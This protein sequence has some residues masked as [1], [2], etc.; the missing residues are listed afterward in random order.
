[1]KTLRQWYDGLS[2][3]AQRWLTKYCNHWFDASED[4]CYRKIKK[5][6]IEDAVNDM[7][8]SMKSHCSYFSSDDRDFVIRSMLKIISASGASNANTLL[9]KIRVVY[10]DYLPS[11]YHIFY[12]K[13]K[14]DEIF[15][16]LH[17]K[18]T[19]S[20][21]EDDD[22]RYYLCDYL[23]TIKD[24]DNIVIDWN[25]IR[26][27]S[28]DTEAC[29]E[30]IIGR[31][32]FKHIVNDNLYAFIDNLRPR[33]VN[34]LFDELFFCENG[35]TKEQKSQMLR[36]KYLK[37]DSLDRIEDF[38]ERIVSVDHSYLRFIYDIVKSN[39]SIAMKLYAQKKPDGELSG[40]E[41]IPQ[42]YRYPKDIRKLI[43]I[44][45]VCAL[46]NMSKV[47]AGFFKEIAPLV[48]LYGYSFNDI[49]NCL[50]PE[51]AEVA[52]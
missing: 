33:Q 40:N 41:T 49:Y 42:T 50:Y 52:V 26:I 20:W 11:D 5:Q 29:V 10:D 15:D 18:N 35:W 44:A 45:H 37:E 30:E 6:S 23:Y 38:F 19:H 27:S 36:R 51:E 31:E 1:M 8:N 4:D 46:Q 14:Q 12:D 3:P 43:R 25:R 13:D 34:S 28:N 24:Y 9:E 7:L 2:E 21:E 48:K 39:P 17:L 22:K 47:N 32:N 16:K